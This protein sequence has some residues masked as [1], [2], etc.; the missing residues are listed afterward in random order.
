MRTKETDID[1][2]LE[3]TRFLKPLENEAFFTFAE[4]IQNKMKSWFATRVEVVFDGVSVAITEQSTI[5]DLCKIY[6]LRKKN[7]ELE[8][9]L[10]DLLMAEEAWR[11]ES[12]ILSDKLRG[13]ARDLRVKLWQQK[14]YG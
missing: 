3:K 13:A 14:I 8:K 2:Y 12:G 1:Y 4:R 9:D 11:G 5:D 10:H 7:R 6:E